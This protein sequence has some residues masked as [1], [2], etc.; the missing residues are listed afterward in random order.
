MAKKQTR[1]C[2]SVRAEV[3]VRLQRAAAAEGVPMTQ[4]AERFINAA[5]DAVGD[6]QVTRDE[7]LAV[8]PPRKTRRSILTASGFFTF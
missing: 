4:V 6:P 8:L 1:R 5:L 2:F 7:A 3:Y